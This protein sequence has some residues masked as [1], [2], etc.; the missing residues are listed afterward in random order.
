MNTQSKHSDKEMI[1][2][3]RTNHNN[4]EGHYFSLFAIL[5]ITTPHHSA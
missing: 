3:A 2:S 1:F 5:I 4:N